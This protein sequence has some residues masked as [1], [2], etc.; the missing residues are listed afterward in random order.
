MFK[1]LKTIDPS[2]GAESMKYILSQIDCEDKIIIINY[3]PGINVIDIRKTQIRAV[4]DNCSGNKILNMISFLDQTQLKIKNVIITSLIEDDN[5][6]DVREDLIK[7]LP[8]L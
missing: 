2:Y 4:I 5:F 1:N 8:L 6:I 7:Y 3:K